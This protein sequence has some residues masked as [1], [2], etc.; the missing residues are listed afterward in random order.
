M[1]SAWAEKCCKIPRLVGYTWSLLSL[2][3]SG[4]RGQPEPG[5]SCSALGGFLENS[6]L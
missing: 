6:D 4:M 5:P 3:G 2:E 1:Y